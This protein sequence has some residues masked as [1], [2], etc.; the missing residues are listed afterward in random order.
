MGNAVLEKL[1]QERTEVQAAAVAIAES[2]EFNPDDKTYVELRS[3]GTDLDARIG[4]LAEL[5]EQQQ[6]ADSLDAKLAK[7]AKRQQEQQR[8]SSELVQTRSSWGQ[9]FIDS[10]EWQG[11]GMRGTSPVFELDQEVQTRA[12]PTSIADL[13]AAGLT[14]TKYQMD[15]TP[16]RPPTPLMDNVNQVQVSGNAIEV[17]A[18]AKIA[19]GATIVAEEAAKPSAEWGPTV[20]PSVL[21][22]IAVWTQ[23]TRQM[24]EDFATVRSY[25]DGELQFDVAREEEHQ[26]ALALT[27]AS[28][29]IPDATSATLLGAIRVGIGTVQATGY[30][31]TAVLM[32]PSD[33]ADLDVSV[34]GETLNGPVVR[35]Q[36]W[37]LTVIPSTAQ[38]A[39][40][41]I[42]GDFRAAI[43]RFYRSAIALYVTDSHQDTFIKNVFTLL[44]ERRS[45]TAVVRPQALVE[46]SEA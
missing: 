7:A 9:R 6:S 11:Y 42:V 36:F 1:I 26:A 21:D 12:L 32:N 17:I 41:A 25:I 14:P 8:T 23:L 16:P 24:V 18:W 33:W 27:A 28:A 13:V 10:P 45:K 43:T 19:G 40:T 20:T 37:G 31:P 46:C 5:L 15:V 34:M 2:E 35:Q 30:N 39:G 38:A 3:R 29:S 22:T 44:A 4:S